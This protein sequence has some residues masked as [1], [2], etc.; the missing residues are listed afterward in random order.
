MGQ[1]DQAEQSLRSAATRLDAL[2]STGRLPDAPRR[3][4]AIVYQRL[5]DLYSFRDRRE[6][7]LTWARKAVAEAESLWRATPGD[8]SSRSALASAS[9]EF[10]KAL[11]G[12]DQYAEALERVR[13]ARALLEAGLRDN[14]VDARQTQ[15]LLFVLYAEGLYCW[16]LGDLPGA[17]AVRE[18]AL[19]VAED[20]LR[21]DPSDRWSQ[22][23]VAVAAGALGEVVLAAGDAKRAVRL[24][25]QAL[26]IS[27][28]AVS[29][30][31]QY[32]FA[33]LQVASGEHGLGRALLAE[34]TA[35]SLAEGCAALERVRVYWSGLQS[36]D[37]LPPGETGGS[38]SFRDG[39][40]A[41]GPRVS[42]LVSAGNEKTS[43]AGWTVSVKGKATIVEAPEG[44]S[45]IVFVDV[46]AM[47]PDAAISEAWAAY[48]PDAKWPLKAK[49]DSSDKDGWTHQKTYSYQTSPNER[50]G[51]A[52]GTARH[53]DLHL[54]WIYDMADPV[55]EKRGAQ[56][57]L[58]FGRLF[59]K[60]YSRETFAGRK[61][62][63]LDEARIK[64]LGAFIERGHG[65]ARR[66]RSL[67]RAR[68]G[69][70]GGVR[71][72]VR[73]EGARE[74][75]EARRR[76]ALHDRF[77]HESDDDDAARA[78]SSTRRSSRGR[79][80][81]RSSCRSSSSGTPTRRARCWSST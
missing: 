6:E 47:E 32:A 1:L 18:H 50:R 40:R 14:P 29:E 19:E 4:L 69:R 52:A 21:T 13:Q 57:A 26:A 55:A 46:T 60:G 16:R 45:R 15:V 61:A 27:N 43:N 51:V 56:V 70:Q 12:Q 5:A 74:A 30:D 9:Y 33:R 3:R 65:A 49:T 34:D 67:A 59:P 10:A 58:I 36:R 42:S 64:E 63:S 72:R 23:G 31:P 62:N 39:S 66:A 78:G 11:A 7:A 22:M 48:R 25:R 73:R 20:A 71:G 53:G 37:E 76:H 80:R 77:E 75:G 8:P 54:V 24:F 44:D 38:S 41:A 2:A 35:P 17:I 79:R 68:A 28:R 81:S